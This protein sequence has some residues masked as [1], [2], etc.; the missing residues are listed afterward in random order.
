MQS[1]NRQAAAWENRSGGRAHLLAL[2]KALLC[3][4]V[5]LLHRGQAFVLRPAR[6]SA[7]A[8]ALPGGVLVPGCGTS[9]CS[10]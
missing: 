1:H 2:A 8:T 6:R 3:L 4:P 5:L 7:F 10:L 9:R